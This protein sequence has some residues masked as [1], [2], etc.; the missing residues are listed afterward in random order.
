MKKTFTPAIITLAAVL[1]LSGCGARNYSVREQQVEVHR[2]YEKIDPS[3][4]V[5]ADFYDLLLFTS[6][7]RKTIDRT[8]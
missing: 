7:R 2:T 5:I 3:P 8:H 4:A 1:L 6:M